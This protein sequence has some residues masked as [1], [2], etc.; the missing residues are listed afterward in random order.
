VCSDCRVQNKADKIIC[1]ENPK[2]LTHTRKRRSGREGGKKYKEGRE[3]SRQGRSGK[4][5]K[6]GERRLWLY[7]YF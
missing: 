2:E 5:E 6:G 7:N 3:T 4:G 1:I